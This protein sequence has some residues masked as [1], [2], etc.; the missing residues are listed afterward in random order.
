MED[1]ED[2]DESVEVDTEASDEPSS[3]ELA[4][5]V[6]LCIFSPRSRLANLRFIWFLYCCLCC[7]DD[8]EEEEGEEEGKEEAWCVVVEVNTRESFAVWR[9]YL[10]Y[11]F[12]TACSV[13]CERC[14][15]DEFSIVRT[16]KCVCVWGGK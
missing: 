13:L 14:S 1:V 8:E 5:L 7:F 12:F 15:K 10:R 6:S 16:K 9:K 4:T 11:R 2:A 3:T